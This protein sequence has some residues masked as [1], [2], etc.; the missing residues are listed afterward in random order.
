MEY[1]G[2]IVNNE[3]AINYDFITYQL[4]KHNINVNKQD[5]K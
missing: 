4:I 1:N 5:V 2:V 3:K